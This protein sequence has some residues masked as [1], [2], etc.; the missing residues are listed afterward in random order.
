MPD[1]VSPHDTTRLQADVVLEGG[2]V[3]GIGHVG[4]LSIMEEMGYSWVNIAGT[5]AGAHSVVQVPLPRQQFSV[6]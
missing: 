6:R 2:G 4:A 3:R 1:P 5:S